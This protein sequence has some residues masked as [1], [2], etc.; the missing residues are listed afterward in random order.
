MAKKSGI[1]SAW[2]HLSRFSI[3]ITSSGV[4]LPGGNRGS[5]WRKRKRQR[6]G[7][8]RRQTEKMA[9]QN[10]IA[11]MAWRQRIAAAANREAGAAS[12]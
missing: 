2:Q 6:S 10:N 11:R 8:K 5:I 4:S 1:N 9:W 3:G 12:A 7:R